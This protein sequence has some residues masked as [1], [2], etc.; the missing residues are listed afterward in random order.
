MFR[1]PKKRLGY[2]S[3]SSSLSEA[4]DILSHPWFKGITLSEIESKSLI[5]H[6]PYLSKTREEYLEAMSPEEMKAIK[7]FNISLHAQIT[8][9][10]NFKL[11]SR[12]S[13]VRAKQTKSKNG[14]LFAMSKIDLYITFI[15]LI[16]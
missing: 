6:A 5:P 10:R 2:R 11:Y 15:Y 7:N 9:I 8:V 13:T 4:D 12:R 1:T 14:P 3:E 16:H